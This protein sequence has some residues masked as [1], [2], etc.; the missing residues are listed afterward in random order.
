MPTWTGIAR[1]S[2]VQ[3][4]A[5]NFTPYSISDR[6]VSVRRPGV[7][8]PRVSVSMRRARSR[9]HIGHTTAVSR[10]TM[11]AL[12]KFLSRAAPNPLHADD[13]R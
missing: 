11:S 12:D 7:S 8:R 4:A 9:P 2:A 3:R 1:D 10:A 13:E 6:V 5:V